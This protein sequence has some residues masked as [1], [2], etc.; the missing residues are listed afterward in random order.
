MW[1]LLA[2]A[3]GRYAV[4]SFI[5][6]HK[7][8]INKPRE[9]GNKGTK[10]STP[11]IEWLMQGSIKSRKTLKEEGHADATNGFVGCAPNLDGME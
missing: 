3:S 10:K 11:E 4:N 1:G 9:P 2:P 6:L 8:P 5:Y 7:L